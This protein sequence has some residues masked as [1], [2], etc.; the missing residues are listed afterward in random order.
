MHSSERQF[1]RVGAIA[2]IAGLLIYGGSAVL[3][4]GTAPHETEAAFAHYAQESNWA[5]IHL[6][7]LLGILLMSTAAIALAWRLRQG[8]I[9]WPTLAGAAIAVFA[10]VYAVF[11]AVDGVALGIMVERW[12]QAPPERQELLYETAF[13]VRQ[14]EAGLFGIQWLIFGLATGLFSAAFFASSAAPFRLTWMSAMG[15]LSALAS[16]GALLFGVAQARLGFSETSMV[17]QAGLF[18]GAAWTL[19]VGLFLLRHPVQVGGV[20]GVRVEASR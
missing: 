10:A 7:E 8:S 18:I 17:F 16:L 3:H 13:A 2:A 12:E 14:I 15:W 1:S 11:I 4:P 6:G 20:D 9:V 5:L 19:G